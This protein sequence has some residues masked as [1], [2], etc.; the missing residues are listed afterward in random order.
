[1]LKI[2]KA[3]A[4]SGK[5]HLLAGF[6][7]E[8][9]FRNELTPSLEGRDLQFDEIL[10]VTFTNKAT[11]EMKKRIVEDIY[12]LSQNPTESPYYK[13]L[14]AAGENGKAPSDETIKK[15][16]HGILTQMLN[17]Y[18]DLHISTIDSFFQRVLKSFAHELSVQGNYELELDSDSV[19]DHA[20][21]D[22]M[23]GLDTDNS[24]TFG[25]MLEF[26]KYIL[27]DGKKWSLHNE[28]KRLA[29]VLT[30]E[31]YQ[32]NYERIKA[33][34]SD[35]KAM[36]DY[37]KLVN[38]TISQWRRDFKAIGR[39]GTKALMEWDNGSLDKFNGKSRCPFAHFAKWEKGQTTDVKKDNITKWAEDS[40]A[41][42]SAG[43]NSKKGAATSSMPEELK[44]R[45][46][47]ALNDG[48]SHQTGD[49]HRDY[50]SALAIKKNF[51]QLCLLIKLEEAA[52]AYCERQGV[53]LLS[54]TTQLLNAL[55]GKEKAPFVYEKTGTSIVSYMIDEFQ[56]T[57]EMQWNN[58]RP[59]L[60]D[61]LDNGNRNL[62][63]GDVKQSIYRWRNG[64]WELL[65]HK[66]EE[67]FRAHLL[68][69][70]THTLDENW[71]SDHAIIDFNNAF[72]K[73]ATEEID[74]DASGL[75][76]SLVSGIYS[77]VEQK[78]SD[79]R[80]SIKQGN[81][82]YMPLGS[83][84]EKK[85][86]MIDIAMKN[87]P[88]VVIGMQKKGYQAKDILILCR[89]KDECQR[90]AES[91]LA[92]H[93]EHPDTKWNFDIITG[94]ALKLGSRNS[95]MAIIN[96][97]YSLKEPKSEYRRCVAAC[98]LLALRGMDMGDAIAL[99]T[100]QP[101][102]M[103]DISGLASLPLYEIAERLERLLPDEV[104]TS[105]RCFLLALRD[106]VLDFCKKQGPS[107]VDFLAWWEQRGCT[108]S[109]TTPEGH[110]AIR[111]MTIHQSKGLGEKVVILPF[112]EG[113]LGI[114]AYHSPLLWCVP[115]DGKLK[116][117]GLVL[118]ILATSDL[119]DT[120]FHDD[121]Q[122]EYRRN[123]TDNLNVVYVAF[124]RAKNEMIIMSPKVKPDKGQ[125]TIEKYIE[126][127]ASNNNYKHLV[128]ELKLDDI[129]NDEAKNDAKGGAD[130]KAKDDSNGKAGSK[131]KNWPKPKTLATRQEDLF[132]NVECAPVLMVKE[133]DYAPISGPVARGNTLHDALSAIVSLDSIEE[134]VRQLFTSGR[135]ELHGMTLDEVLQ[136]VRQLLNRKEVGEWFSPENTVLNERNI[137]TVST[138]T[139]RPDRIV[140]TPDN[141]AIVI[142]YKT[143]AEHESK[144]KKQVA[145]YMKLLSQM[146]FGN[147][148]GYLL[149]LEPFKIEQVTQ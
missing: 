53:R 26:N 39:E 13:Q 141:R 103:T 134:P 116:S 119:K 123:V 8:L 80:S 101:E 112:I 125:G 85:A 96:M 28:L 30:S 122:E 136:T 6:Y 79:A 29:K 128:K 12:T 40:E 21:S 106:M 46:Q 92:Y 37:I 3:S 20:V 65:N 9:L 132:E 105:D 93:N 35:K 62:I 25:W 78:V 138:H 89:Q 95:V 54:N 7:I 142:D 111:I 140:I 57:S 121:Y 139:Q 5:T 114:D 102:C 19:L 100:A 75:D 149:Y 144:H 120:I 48:I 137:V 41:W 33:F 52:E 148:E 50:L 107:L 131:S 17:D 1:M 4:G 16:A 56:D 47:K 59:L 42:F 86:E 71:R 45:L 145:Y 115:R 104:R 147:V 126:D 31:D 90:C 68:E 88:M 109:V 44:D 129:E 108:K 36:D 64:N 98:S 61:S 110:N 130:D 99:Y 81:V 87:L 34:T 2:T 60:A 32:K 135:S 146:G 15:R 127:F 82:Y 117:E 76:M 133:S 38:E 63:V 84:N 72:F 124:T 70:K 43:K 77:D 24:G 67:Y 74:G 73:F 49:A 51:Y 83:G 18:S 23:L 118:P 66:V 11:A 27:K 22:F 10:A 94:E 143:G 69:G 91:L 55:I 113:S 58:F 97:M 14:K